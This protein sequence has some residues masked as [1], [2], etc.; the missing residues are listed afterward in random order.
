MP[1]GT[2]SAFDEHVGLGEVQSEDGD[3]Y[4]F[5][6][7]E[8]ADGSRTIEVGTPVEFDLM[9]KFGRLEASGLRPRHDR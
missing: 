8:I 2:V 6:C 3:V 5:H 9:R 4:L 1:A 7:V